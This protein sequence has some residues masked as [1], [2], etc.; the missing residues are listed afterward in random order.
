MSDLD[1]DTEVSAKPSLLAAYTAALRDFREVYPEGA[2]VYLLDCFLTIARL[3]G[4]S[5]SEVSES[6]GVSLAAVSRYAGVLGTRGGRSNR[7][8]GLKL[9]ESRE[10]LHDSR[11]KTLHLTPKGRRLAQRMMSHFE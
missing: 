7:G 2:T 5:M 6:M 11:Y 8:K 9:I 4:E 10:D 3:E 1:T